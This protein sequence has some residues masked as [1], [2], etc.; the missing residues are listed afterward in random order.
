MDQLQYDLLAE[1]IGRWKADVLE[2]YLR[3]EEIDNESQD[4]TEE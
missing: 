2:S 1:I 4:N 3:S